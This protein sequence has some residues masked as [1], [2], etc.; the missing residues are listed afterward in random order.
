MVA[1]PAFFHC[2]GHTSSLCSSTYLNARSVRS[3][4][5]TARPTGRSLMVT[6]RTV[7]VGSMMNSARSVTE[8]SRSSTSYAFDTRLVRSL[9]SGKRTVPRPPSER[10]SFVHASSAYS[11][12]TVMPSTSAP[13]ASNSSRR[14]LNST[15]SVVHTNV[16]ASGAVKNT[17]H[18]FF[19][20]YSPRRTSP[21]LPF[22][23]TAVAVKSGAAS[24][25]RTLR[26]PC[27]TA[28]ATSSATSMTWTAVESPT[29]H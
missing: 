5:S 24:C 27:A 6:W 19:S 21:N 2:D 1:S 29:A 9:T 14:S 15:I 22:G 26:A 10:F 25:G 4:S 18:R 28:A 12:S 11:L 16:N 13:S 23:I 20:A 17:S 8:S 3:A 7:P